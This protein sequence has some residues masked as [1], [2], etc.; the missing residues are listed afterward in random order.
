MNNNFKNL[1]T[2]RDFQKYIDDNNILS[3][4]D[5]FKNYSSVYNRYLRL[6]PKNERK[7]VFRNKEEI[8]KPFSDLEDFKKY[9]EENNIK[10]LKE[11]RKSH[12][13]MY[14]KYLKLKKSSNDIEELKLERYIFKYDNLKTL[15]DFQKYIDE[16]NI[17]SKSDFREN[18]S[19]ANRF[20]RIIPKED[21]KLLK[22]K[23]KSK[24]HLFWDDFSSLGDFQK[25]IDDNKIY[26]PIDFKTNYPK[27]YDRFCR[28][29]SKDD[30]Q[31]LI[32]GI[33]LNNSDKKHR[34]Y[35]ERYLI[36]LLKDN[37]IK[38]IPEKTF[39]D[40][41]RKSLLRYDLYLPEYNIIIEYHGEQHFNKNT[42]YSSNELIENDKIKYEYAIDHNIYILYFTLNKSKLEKFGY[43]TEVITD[44]KILIRKIK[45]LD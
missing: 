17:N 39:S 26:R 11:F 41:K 43:F 21:R 36:K 19:L 37:D 40:L 28:V 30:K 42:L 44:S 15:E 9:I 20:F 29:I 5:F 24:H 27:I 3:N 8:K 33:S 16:N 31:K 1:N 12:K 22:F 35:G 38:F 25:F 34:S 45:G 32:Y 14:E 6:I 13:T 10:S 23:E 2:L 4:K 7:L 18:K